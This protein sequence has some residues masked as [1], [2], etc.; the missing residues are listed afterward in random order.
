MLTFEPWVITACFW[1]YEWNAGINTP[2]GLGVKRDPGGI[3]F[4]FG[5]LLFRK[6]R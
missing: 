5:P 6:W 4:Q 2:W 3:G 1:G